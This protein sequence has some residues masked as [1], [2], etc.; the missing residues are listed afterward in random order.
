[1]IFE[2]P[3]QARSLISMGVSLGC[4]LLIAAFIKLLPSL[5]LIVEDVRHVVRD[6]THGA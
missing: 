4:G 3:M 2:T 1:M 6:D 5:H